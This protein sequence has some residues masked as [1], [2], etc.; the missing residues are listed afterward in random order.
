MPPFFSNLLPEGGHRRL[1]GGVAD[2]VGVHELLRQVQRHLLVVRQALRSG[3]HAQRLDG[4]CMDARLDSQGCVHVPFKLVAHMARR[5]TYHQFADARVQHA[6]KAQV[7]AHTGHA[8]QQHGAAQQRQERA[9]NPLART[10]SQGVGG[11][12][13]GGS[14]GSS[15]GQGQAIGHGMSFHRLAST[16]PASMSFRQRVWPSGH[17]RSK[18]GAQS[19]GGW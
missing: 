2:A 4:V 8:L 15:V 1:P 3:T 18:H 19:S 17:S 13:L 6:V 14:H 5:C 7:L 9:L 11:S 12:T 10:G 16:R